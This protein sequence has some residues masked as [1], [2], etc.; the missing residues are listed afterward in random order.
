MSDIIKRLNNRIQEIAT[1]YNI[2]DHKAFILWYLSYSRFDSMNDAYA[3]ICDGANDRGIDAIYI[4]EDHSKVVLVQSKYHHKGIHPISKSLLQAE[5]KKL[6]D[7]IEKITGSDKQFY[8]LLEEASSTV[9]KKI[10][11]ARRFIKKN[12]FEIEVIFITSYKMDQN[13]KKSIEKN[14]KARQVKP[15]I[16]SRED[17]PEMVN[18]WEAGVAPHIPEVDLPV[19]KQLYN[20]K[21]KGKESTVIIFSTKG[22]NLS[23]LYDKYQNRIFARNIRLDLGRS[24][25]NKEIENT[26]KTDPKNFFYLNNGISIICDG[27]KF[28]KNRL[29]IFQCQIINGQQT[30]RA[31]YNQPNNSKKVDVLV[32]VIKVNRK[33]GKYEELLSKIVCGTNR[34]NPISVSDLM[35]ND[36]KQVELKRNFKR[37]GYLYIRKKQTKRSARSNWHGKKWSAEIKKEDLAQYLGATQLNDPAFIRTTGKTS[38]FKRD[39]YQKLFNRNDV[40]WY[41]LHMYLGQFIEGIARNNINGIAKNR[42]KKA[43]WWDARWVVMNIFWDRNRVILLDNNSREKIIAAFKKDDSRFKKSLGK[44]LKKLFSVAN[45]TYLQRKKYITGNRKSRNDFFG[46]KDCKKW[47]EQMISKREL[48]TLEKKM[49]DELKDFWEERKTA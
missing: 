35:S 30:T 46:L 40:E 18:D 37:K 24:E 25:I 17:M 48:H 44:I 27:Y 16:F 39:T 9:Q 43:Q 14:L 10:R 38:L 8:T 19:K 32:R 26:I 29:K 12:C 7:T 33:I 3:C 11:K 23:K 4:N 45:K 47:T 28:Y 49:T 41:E 22:N 36:P 13:T 6:Q 42:R 34:Q 5:S 1:E 31:L 20:K 15:I 2:P 21:L